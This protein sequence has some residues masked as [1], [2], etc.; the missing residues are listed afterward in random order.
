METHEKNIAICY[1]TQDEDKDN[2]CE[3]TDQRLL[4]RKK[5]RVYEYLIGRVRSLQINRRKLL[6]PIIFSGIFTPLIAVGFFEGFFHP[7]IAALFMVTGIFTFYLGWMGQE[8]FTIEHD[9][10]HTDFSI[11]HAGQNLLA[12]ID[13]TNDYLE[14][15]PMEFQS[16]YLFSPADIESSKTEDI[17]TIP[18]PYELYTYQHL[19]E[20]LQASSG[21][22]EGM[23]W[24]IDPLK[25]EGQ[26]KYEPSKEDGRLRPVLKEKINRNAVLRKYTIHEFLL[27]SHKK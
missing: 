11:D 9:Q 3:L 21:Q 26:I 7:V 5:G 24:A 19:K 14:Q 2:T 20:Y 1:F 10:G 13:F 8:V 15:V 27:T 22:P 18:P 16:V 23:I 6:I 17:L 12:F 4:V 25:T